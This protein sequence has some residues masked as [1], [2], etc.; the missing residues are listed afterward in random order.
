[1][2]Q[3]ADKAVAIPCKFSAVTNSNAHFATHRA[4]IRVLGVTII[5]ALSPNRV[6]PLTGWPHYL[7]RHVAEVESCSRD[8]KLIR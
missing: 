5:M 3:P 7:C 2:Q 6:G 4:T 1:M 8:C